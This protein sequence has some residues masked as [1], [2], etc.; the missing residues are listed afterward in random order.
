IGR[1]STIRSGHGMTF[2]GTIVRGNHVS[3]C[4]ICGITG[5]GGN[6]GILIENNTLVGNCWH[7]LQFNWESAAIKVHGVRNGLIRLNTIIDTLYGDGIWTDWANENER[8]CYNFIF[9][10]Q[11]AC[12]GAIFVEA[13]DVPNRIDHNVII[14][15]NTYR[16][17][18]NPADLWDGGHGIVTLDS[19]EIWSEENVIFGVE[20]EAHNMRMGS[21]D[22][23]FN[24][25]GALGIRHRVIKNII[26]KCNRAILFSNQ[27]NFSDGN[28]VDE[29]SL[30]KNYSIAIEPPG[31]VFQLFS[32][33]SACR[34]LNWEENGRSVSIN[35]NYDLEAMTMKFDI[36][37]NGGTMTKEIVIGQ[38]FSL[39]DVFEF[40]A[41]V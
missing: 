21:P 13:S 27:Q 24:G 9:N 4:G 19:S 16:F 40:M 38:L 36:R 14:S 1:E 3:H 18:K 25:H 37:Y 11:N 41:K 39:D 35:Y 22:R 2:G 31:T 7:D 12:H 26:A 23:I 20:G 6:E 28:I 30:C 29:R 10:T 32:L 8:L 34:Y 33:N 5:L 15:C 17:E